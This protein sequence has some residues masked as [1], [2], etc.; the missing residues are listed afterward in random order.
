MKIPIEERL[1][2]TIEEAGRIAFG[3]GR[4]ASYRAARRGDL[5]IITIGKRKKVV[6]KA[7]LYRRYGYDV[8]MPDLQAAVEDALGATG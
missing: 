7:E 1:Y 6:P 4:S 5:P 8:P 3:Y 2:F